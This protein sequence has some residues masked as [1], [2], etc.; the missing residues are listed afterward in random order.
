MGFVPS[1][2]K[3]YIDELL[4]V[5]PPSYNWK[6]YFRRFFGSSSKIYTKKTRRKYNK[7]FPSNPALKIKPKKGL[8]VLWPTD[9]TYTHRGIASPS[10]LKYIIT[11]WYSYTEIANDI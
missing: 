6:G 8:T 9:W 10:Q 4:E 3:S 1:E 11:G 7:R 2:L 5:T